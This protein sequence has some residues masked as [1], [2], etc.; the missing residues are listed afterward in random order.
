VISSV[1]NGAF[2]AMVV[3]NAAQIDHVMQLAE[4]ALKTDLFRGACKKIVVASIG[5]TASE[6]LKHHDLP[7]DFEP[8]HPKMGILVKEFSEQ[9][10]ALR[11]A[12]SGQRH[13]V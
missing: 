7:V 6:T 3:T 5:P 12:K 9:V 1:L 8:S 13:D 10:H 2:D 4:R 11:Q